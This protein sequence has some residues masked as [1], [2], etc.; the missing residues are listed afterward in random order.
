[1]TAHRPL[2]EINEAFRDLAAGVG[3]RTVIDLR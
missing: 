3:I 2:D 1:V